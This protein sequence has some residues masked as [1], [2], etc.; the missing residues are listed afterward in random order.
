MSKENVLPVR[1]KDCGHAW[2][3]PQDLPKEV[4]EWIKEVRK[5]RCPQCDAPIKRLLI[6][7]GST[8]EEPPVVATTERN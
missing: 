7:F 1:C 8:E 4:G 5:M 6:S 3:E 2:D